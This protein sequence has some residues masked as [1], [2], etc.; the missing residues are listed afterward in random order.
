MKGKDELKDLA[1]RIAE[2]VGRM[3]QEAGKNIDQFELQTEEGITKGKNF[4]N[5]SK[6]R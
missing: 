3:D 1:M 4:E 6:K 5:I 2:F